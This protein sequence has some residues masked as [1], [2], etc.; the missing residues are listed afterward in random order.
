MRSFLIAALAGTVLGSEASSYAGPFLELEDGADTVVVLKAT[1]ERDVSVTGC[2]ALYG[3]P[4]VCAMHGRTSAAG[5]RI[6]SLTGSA[7]A[8]DTAHANQIDANAARINQLSSSITDTGSRTTELEIEQM[9]SMKTLKALFDALATRVDNLDKEHDDAVK[10]LSAADTAL[11][12]KDTELQNAINAELQDHK[13]EVQALAEEDAELIKTD[14]TLAAQITDM[15][16][17]VK[18]LTGDRGAK[19]AVGNQGDRKSVV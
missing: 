13:D 11:A 2:S 17:T 7:S 5:A 18:T 16:A 9:N 15:I 1:G 8:T 12:T 10:S 14:A 6:T 3:T 19:G 4:K